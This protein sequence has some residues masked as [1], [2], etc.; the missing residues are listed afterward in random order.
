MVAEIASGRPYP[1]VAGYPVR[2]VPAGNQL[3]VNTKA[4]PDNPFEP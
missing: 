1:V 2:Q 4:H 3:M